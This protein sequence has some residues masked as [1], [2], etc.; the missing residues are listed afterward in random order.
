MPSGPAPVEFMLGLQRRLEIPSTS[1]RQ[2]EDADHRRRAR[3]APEW[4]R[5]RAD[6]RATLSIAPARAALSGRAAD[7]AAGRIE[8]R[9]DDARRGE[10]RVVLDEQQVDHQPDDLSRRE[11]LAGDLVGGLGEAAGG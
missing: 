10:Q 4:S 11:V 9:L 6:L 7:R 1:V 5:G 3:C 2:V 8:Q